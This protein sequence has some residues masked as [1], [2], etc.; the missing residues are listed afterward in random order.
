[1]NVKNFI[2]QL[3]HPKIRIFNKAARRDEKENQQFTIF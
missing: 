1:M 3:T 2:Y